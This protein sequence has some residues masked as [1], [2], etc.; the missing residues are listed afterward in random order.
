MDVLLSP[1]GQPSPPVGAGPG[2][3]LKLAAR[4]ESKAQKNNRNEKAV[5]GVHFRP[6]LLFRVPTR[7]IQ[8]KKVTFFSMKLVHSGGTSVSGKIA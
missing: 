6:P 1:S 2:L 7:L 8:S 3:A 5:A 4:E